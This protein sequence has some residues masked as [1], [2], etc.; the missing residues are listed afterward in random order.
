MISI[1]IPVYNA[2]PYLPTCLDSIQCQTESSLQVILVDDGS[3]DDSY[4]IAQ[5][6]AKKDKRIELYTIPHAGQSAARNEGLKHAEGEFIAFVDADDRL[7]PDWCKRHLEAIKGVDY[8]QSGYRRADEKEVQGWKV[9]RRRLSSN[10]Y[11]FTSPC[12]RLYRRSAINSLRFEQGMIYEDILWSVDLWT[13]GASFRRIRYAGYLYTKNPNSTT[14]RPH[15]DAQKRVLEELINRLPKVS[16]KGKI[17]I[18]YTYLRL[19]IYFLKQ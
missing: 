11:R 19:K 14:S 12:M 15:P 3:I 16:I 17:I 6:Y 1:I 10:R 18:L 5:A 8:V 4:A 9:G 2:A 13:S 7:A